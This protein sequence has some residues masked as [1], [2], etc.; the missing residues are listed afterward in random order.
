MRIGI[1]TLPLHT[2]YGGILQAYALQTVLERMGHE[3]VVLNK[4]HIVIPKGIKQQLRYVKR[5][6]SKYLLGR[7]VDVFYEKNTLRRF[8]I[9]STNT[10]HF[11]DSYIH[12]YICND[13][14][15]LNNNDLGLDAIVVGSDQIWRP[16][17]ISIV[18][19]EPTTRAFL[20]FAKDWDVKKLVYA[21]SFGTEEWE[22]TEE[23]TRNCRDLSKLFDGISVRENSGVKLCKEYLNVDSTHVLDPT[24]L[25]H[26]ED[27]L[28]LLPSRESTY[29]RK[30]LMCY[31]LDMNDEKMSLMERIA[32]EKE[33]CLDKRFCQK[34][35]PLD[36]KPAV[37][38]WLAAFRDA[39]FVVTD[40]FHACVFSILFRKPFVV[41]G[42][43]DRGMGRFNSLLEIFG[44][45]K[46]L[47]LDCSEYVE[48]DDYSVGEDACYLLENKRTVSMLFLEENLK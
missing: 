2:N 25:L 22:Y 42:N 24:M 36:S 39:D 33:L 15:Q 18:L 38:D 43:R 23:E 3:V 30:T 19:R 7:D 27:Y 11:I 5:I 9:L 16:K 14:S 10:Q 13:F 20:D 6:V 32:S 34:I 17:Y 4:D 29:K 31:I 48:G 40:S 12:S 1:L 46:N 35:G 47:I 28:A 41:V 45:K 8:Q 21:A 37:E 44:L 26:R